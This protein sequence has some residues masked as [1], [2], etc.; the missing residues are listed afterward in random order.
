[1]SSGKLWCSPS[2]PVVWERQFQNV[3][4]G[5]VKVHTRVT[6]VLFNRAPFP[7]LW[8]TLDSKDRT[9]DPSHPLLCS[10]VPVLAWPAAQRFV[11]YL[12]A[13]GFGHLAS[14]RQGRRHA[15]GLEKKEFAQIHNTL[16]PKSPGARLTVINFVQMALCSDGRPF[17]DPGGIA[18]GTDA[19]NKR[20]FYSIVASWQRLGEG[21]GTLVH[22][23]AVIAARIGILTMYAFVCGATC[24]RE[25]SRTCKCGQHRPIQVH[26]EGAIAMALSTVLRQVSGQRWNL[27]IELHHYNAN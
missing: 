19:S 20:S 4:D 12:P 17:C 25:P 9:L 15:E 26:I 2:R 21:A 6:F 10:R 1:M 13:H 14:G 24:A 16:L 23:V 11:N 18:N 22:R 27:A 8:S 3:P 7:G 5:L